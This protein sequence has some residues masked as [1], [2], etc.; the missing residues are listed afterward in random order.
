MSIRRWT[1]TR[2]PDGNITMTFLL[3]PGLPIN[4]NH[5]FMVK[6]NDKGIPTSFMQTLQ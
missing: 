1:S 3:P 4:M 5:T 2:K 6:P